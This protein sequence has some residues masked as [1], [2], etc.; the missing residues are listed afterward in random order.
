MGS[1]KQESNISIFIEERFHPVI[2]TDAALVDPENE[3]EPAA[4]LQADCLEERKRTCQYCQKKL[5]K[6]S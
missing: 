4:C 6:S 3:I 5:S 2:T 1:V